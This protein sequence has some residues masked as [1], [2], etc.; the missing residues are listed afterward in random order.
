M[1][2]ECRLW[3]LWRPSTEGE[4]TGLVSSRVS[5]PFPDPVVGMEAV[6][7]HP[8]CEQVPGLPV[9]ILRLGQD[10]GAAAQFSHADPGSVLQPMFMTPASSGGECNTLNSVGRRLW[11]D[12]GR[13]LA[14]W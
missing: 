2:R 6:A 7:A 10:A 1:S 12:R 5:Q 14:F 4:E 11:A 9:R 13:R 3:P 8:G